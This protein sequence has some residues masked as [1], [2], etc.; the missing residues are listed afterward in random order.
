MPLYMLFFDRAVKAFDMAITLGMAR[1]VV[2]VNDRTGAD[3]HAEVFFELVT[4]ICLDMF[5]RERS[6]TEELVEEVLGVGAVQF[7]VTKGKGKTS[8]QIHCRDDVAF[9]IVQPLRRSFFSDRFCR[10]ASRPVRA[11][12]RSF[13]WPLKSF[14]CF[15]KSLMIRPTVDSDM[16]FNPLALQKRSTAGLTASL[17]TPGCSVR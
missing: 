1:V 6:H 9:N 10:T 13:C 5:D 14:P 16:V 2:K 8:D 11:I 3:V 17:P 4:I 7:F 12:M 15:F